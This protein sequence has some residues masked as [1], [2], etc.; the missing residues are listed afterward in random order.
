MSTQH[1]RLA[2]PARGHPFR[3]SIAHFQKLDR[4][5]RDDGDMKLFMLSFAA[6]FV[7]FTTF[8]L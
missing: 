7:C 3:H 2:G 8:L 5:R 6:F 4:K 1:L